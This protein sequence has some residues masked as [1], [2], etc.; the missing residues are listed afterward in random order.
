MPALLAVRPGPR[1]PKL[2]PRWSDQLTLVPRIESMARHAGHARGEAAVKTRADLLPRRFCRRGRGPLEY[3]EAAAPQACCPGDPHAVRQASRRAPHR[4]ARW[5]RRVAQRK[6]SRVARAVPLGIGG[7]VGARQ[8]SAPERRER[9][10]DVPSPGRNPATAPCP[11]P[12]RP[13][14]DVRRMCGI[15]GLGPTGQRPLVHADCVRD[16]VTF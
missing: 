6:A 7:G 3:L 1:A 16:G 15:C 2:R 12:P 9:R 11:G 10:R 8:W 4:V 5:L 14:R 13:S